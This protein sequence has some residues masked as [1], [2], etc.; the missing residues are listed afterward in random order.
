MVKWK[1]KSISDVC[2]VFTDGDWIESKDQSKK[3]IRLIQTGNVG[4][5]KFKDRIKK[6]RYISETTFNRLNCTEIFEGDCLV[7]RLPDPVGRACIV[8]NTGEKMIT[9]VDCTIIRFIPGGI[10]PKYFIYYAQSVRYL[11]D[12]ESLTTGTT[13]NRISRKNLGIIKI[14]YPPLPEQKRIVAILEEAF[15]GIEQV[16][17]N[18]EKNILNTKE[19]FES[20]KSQFFQNLEIA[21]SNLPIASVC[22]EIFAGGDAPKD[23]FS[24]EKTKK[25]KI[26]IIANAVK[27]NGLYGFTD[28]NRVNE[29]SITIA[30]RGSGTG[31]TEIRNE[32][33]YPIV[34]LIVLTPNTELIILEFL[35]YAIQNL[36]IFSSGSAI[37]Q[38]TIPMIKE[39]SIPLPSIPVQQAIVQKLDALSTEANKL[40]A[41]YQQKINDLEELKKSVLQKAFNGELKTKKEVA[42]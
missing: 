35:Q 25:Y 31:H 7:S 29:P 42:E 2:E 22:N 40:E 9:A 3:G 41:L 14:E 16:R 5:G 6:A 27:Y 17:A 28:L 11:S 21:E 30:A 23:N 15:E 8:P 20:K 38:L 36:D 39:Y 10:I 37:P 32:P 33:F 1:E 34:R 24:N 4:N 13:R 19:L 26:P 12:V 18:T